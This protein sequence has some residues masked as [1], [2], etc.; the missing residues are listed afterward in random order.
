MVILPCRSRRSPAESGLLRSTHHPRNASH[1]WEDQGTIAAPTARTPHRGKL[2]SGEKESVAQANEPISPP[3]PWSK[4]LSPRYSRRYWRGI[5][6][7]PSA[8]YTRDSTRTGR[9]IL[10]AVVGTL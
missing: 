5:A 7:P 3:L 1:S 6:A 8:T 4:R 10:F 2:A 9:A